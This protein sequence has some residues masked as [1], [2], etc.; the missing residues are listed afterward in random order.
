MF[1]D[2]AVAGSQSQENPL[3]LSEP[4][5]LSKFEENGANIRKDSGL[6]DLQLGDIS[7][8][9]EATR[10][11]YLYL[12]NDESQRVKWNSDSSQRTPLDSQSSKNSFSSLRARST[13]TNMPIAD[14][15]TP[16]DLFQGKTQIEYSQFRINESPISA[17]RTVY[18]M[19]S[20]PDPLVQLQNLSTSATPTEP[21]PSDGY[22]HSIMGLLNLSENDEATPEM[23]TL[24]SPHQTCNSTLE[25]PIEEYMKL[26]PLFD[27]ITGKNFGEL[28]VKVLDKCLH[29]IPLDEFYN[30][31]YASNSLADVVS[32][33]V[34]GIKIHR[35]SPTKSKVDAVKLCRLIIE[36]FRLRNV[37][38]G[39]NSPELIPNLQR[40]SLK[41]HEIL[42]IFLAMK[43]VFDA[44]K[45]EE[46]PSVSDNYLPR[47]SVYKAYCIICMKL[48]QKYPT[49]VLEV[50]KNLLLS[51]SQ[52]GKIVRLN[53][54]NLST[55]RAGKRDDLVYRY[56]GIIWH[57]LLIDD[58]II[59]LVDLSLPD[60]A[61]FFKTTQ[62]KRRSGA[63]NLN[64]KLE[65]L[66][67]SGLLQGAI[68]NLGTLSLALS[69]KK[70]LY[71]FVDLSN[72]FKVPG[73]FLRLWEIIQGQIPQQS[74]WSKD[75]M[76][77]SVEVLKRCNI[78]LMSLM[79]YVREEEFSPE[80]VNRFF[81][82]AILELQVLME[83]SAGDEPLLNFYLAISLFI[84]PIV[85]ASE[86]E[87]EFNS[88]AELRTSLTNCV[89]KL[90]GNMNELPKAVGNNLM[91]FTKILRKMVNFNN[92]LLKSVPKPLA[93]RIAKA[94]GGDP[95]AISDPGMVKHIEERMTTIIHR[96]VITTCNALNW[97]FVPDTL[98][99]SLE[100]RA[101]LINKI[102]KRYIAF[103]R[104]LFICLL[105][106]PASI[107]Q[108]QFDLPNYELSLNIFWTLTRVFH[109]YFISDP[110]ILQLPMKLIEMLVN[111]IMNE[112]QTQAFHSF[113]HLDQELS[114][115]TFKTYWLYSTAVQEYIS[116]VSEIVALSERVS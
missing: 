79:K 26:V 52:L 11:S 47:V 56:K 30:L 95:Q 7:F 4:P 75:N 78:D 91:S 34:D 72:A 116:I 97:E 25:D 15:L 37:L 88:K 5:I 21:E 81:G 14:M 28:L 59:R 101:S 36:T 82:D 64:I 73:C 20:F 80:S 98:R 29:H 69:A 1:P 33:P 100:Y 16:S 66:E 19:S 42:R 45:V 113:S 44:V 71:S 57:H 110:L 8:N 89:T 84:V 76:M 41:M 62:R 86:N 58:E 87:V 38:S 49:K 93:K 32:S 22:E 105:E 35:A 108:D 18:S 46:N 68:P 99:K 43:I 39:P 114:K 90:E 74:Q 10:Q 115:E 67:V 85:F 55:K 54:P 12:E 106:I 63:E 107:G 27:E 111:S 77:K 50:H 70:P 31:L 61:I 40:L 112:F 96:A 6:Q 51:Q 53:F 94:L 109:D 24:F 92:L 103:S 65:P 17:D 2:D 102:T 48:M 3:L 83:D 23:E 60:I 13:N 104:K 9:R